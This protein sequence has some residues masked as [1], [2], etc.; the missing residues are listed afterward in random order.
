MFRNWGPT[1]QHPHHTH[2][3]L[4]SLWEAENE[5]LANS[6]CRQVGRFFQPEAWPKNQDARL[7]VLDKL[8][9]P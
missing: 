6:S 4:D 2:I 8:I 3:L 5:K 9:A 1:L 7:D